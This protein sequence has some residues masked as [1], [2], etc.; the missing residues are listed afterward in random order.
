MVEYLSLD[1]LVQLI[2]PP[3]T[4]PALK[5]FEDNKELFSK[6]RGS[7]HNHQAWE[8]GYRDHI[9]EVM[10]LARQLYSAITINGLRELPFSLSDAL[11]GLYLHDLEKPWKYEFFDGSWRHK[12]GIDKPHEVHEF[13]RKKID[14][15]G[16]SLNEDHINAIEFAHGEHSSVYSARRRGMTPLAAFVHM[17]DVAS[18]RIY[19]D[20]PVKDDKWKNGSGER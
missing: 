3:N 18:A 9:E 16:F 12:P 2:D 8:G 7:V 15:Y 5:L 1:K 11:L 19:F 6:G 17:C 13:V 10:N 4:E 14:E 20:Q